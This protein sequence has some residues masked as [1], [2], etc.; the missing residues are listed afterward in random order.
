[1]P[2]RLPFTAA[3]MVARL[4]SQEGVSEAP[5]GSNVQPYSKAL[6]RGPEPW[7]ADFIGWAMLTLG[8]NLPK[9]VPGFAWTPTLASAMV[10]TLGWAAVAFDD[11]RA[12]DVTFWSFSHNGH[13]EHVEV[14]T[15]P[16]SNGSVPSIGGNTAK[17]GETRSQANGGRV[18]SRIRYRADFVCARRPLYAVPVAPKPSSPVAS[19]YVFTTVKAGDSLASIAAH[20]RGLTW[21]AIYAANRAAIGPNP[22]IL[23]PG[24]RLRLPGVR[25]TAQHSPIVVVRAGDSLATIAAR[26]GKTW[27]QVYA[28]NRAAVGP[29]PNELRIGTRLVIR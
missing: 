10:T 19:S 26:Y 21:Q 20:Y 8:W 18:A 25:P 1:M 13:I 12:G 2:V 6:G 4:R 15:G 5:A 23:R 28:A 14:A 3:Q 27:Q 11:L 29:N 22:N 7:C 9:A 24:T 17:A 16:A